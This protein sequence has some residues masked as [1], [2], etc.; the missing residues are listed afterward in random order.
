[1]LTTTEERVFVISKPINRHSICQIDSGP[2]KKKA[3]SYMSI[4]LD[5]GI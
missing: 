1:M 4:E 5:L 2:N 3:I